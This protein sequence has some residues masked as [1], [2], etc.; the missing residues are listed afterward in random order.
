MNVQN[1]LEMSVEQDG[2]KSDYN[3][4]PTRGI[5]FDQN[6]VMQVTAGGLW[7]TST[8]A[9]QPNDWAWR[10]MFSKLSASVYGKGVNKTLPADYLLALRPDLR[11]H[12]LNDHLHNYPNGEWFIRAYDDTC[13]AIL[14]NQYASIPNTEL[15]AI[16]DKITNETKAPS[17]LTKSSSVTP[18]SLNVR[19]IWKDVQRP[20]NGRGNGGWGIGVA[21]TNGETGQRK[22]RGMPLLQRHSCDN[23]IIVD[24][25]TMGFEFSHRGSVTTKMLVVKS[26]MQEILPFSA[27]LLET[28]I[29]ADEQHIPDFTDVLNGLAIQYGWDE[30]T[31]TAVACGTEGRDTRAAIVNGVTFAAHSIESPDERMDMEILGGKILVAPDSIFG[32]AAR[33]AIQAAR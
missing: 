22:L 4:H 7:E 18:D 29:A 20:D 33:V 3:T 19:I 17:H 31:C 25:N 13:R 26:A 14:S 6:S 28:M 10:Q 27:N 32:Q 15:L 2:H 12:V 23:S 8:V 1:L 24:T 16:L 9:L 21:I 11:A 30:K 5:S